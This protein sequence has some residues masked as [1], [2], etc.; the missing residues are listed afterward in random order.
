MLV[1]KGNLPDIFTYS[2]HICYSFYLEVGLSEKFENDFYLFALCFLVS[3]ATYR[4]SGFIPF[5]CP[6]GN[7]TLRFVHR[8]P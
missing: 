2:Y 5:Q 6:V 1:I 3:L 8:A 4:T 7:Q